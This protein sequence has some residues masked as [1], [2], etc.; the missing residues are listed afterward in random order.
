MLVYYDAQG[1]STQAFLNR[2]VG[3]AVG[4]VLNG[5]VQ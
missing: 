1:V 5:P 4:G 2:A 3:D